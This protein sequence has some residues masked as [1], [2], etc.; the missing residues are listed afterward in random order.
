MKTQI[1]LPVATEA[2]PVRDFRFSIPLKVPTTLNR[3]RRTLVIPHSRPTKLDVFHTF[4]N[5]PPAGLGHP[6]ENTILAAARPGILQ[7]ALSE[8]MSSGD[9]A[10]VNERYPFWPLRSKNRRRVWRRD[11]NRCP[12]YRYRTLRMLSDTIF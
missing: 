2:R 6:T 9:E 7:T 10:V 12:D 11:R 5:P 4:F 8:A 1:L 3:G